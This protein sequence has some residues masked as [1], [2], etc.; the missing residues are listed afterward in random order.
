MLAIND[1]GTHHTHPFE[2]KPN[3]NIYQSRKPEHA[4][5]YKYVFLSRVPILI[6]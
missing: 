1:I 2:V 5:H 4:M 3:S 6:K